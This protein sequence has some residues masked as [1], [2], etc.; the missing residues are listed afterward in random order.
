MIKFSFKNNNNN[1]NK[2]NYFS[3]IIFIAK[4]YSYNLIK[5]TY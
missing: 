4:L 5:I 3:F 2:M 1:N